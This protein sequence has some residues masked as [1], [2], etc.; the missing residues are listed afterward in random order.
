M[1][2]V[3][4]S[5]AVLS[6]L[7]GFVFVPACGGRA[8]LA[9]GQ[10]DGEAP[11]DDGAAGDSSPSGDDGGTTDSNVTGDSPTSSFDGGEGPDGSVPDSGSQD[12]STTGTDSGTVVDSGQEDSA[13]SA[14]G[15][16]DAG[17]HVCSGQ[18][19]D[20]TAPATCGTSCTPCQA[21]A[22]GVASCSGAACS[23]TCEPGY[24]SCATGC[25]GCGDVQT[26]PNNCGTCGHSCGAEACVDG[27]CGAA[28]IATSQANAY[29]IAADDVNVYWTTTGA[30][31]SVLQAPVGGGGATVLYSSAND[32]PAAIAV[33]SG[34]VYFTDEIQPGSVSRVPIGGGASVPVASNLTYPGALAASGGTLFFTENDYTSQNGGSV[35][36]T[37]VGGGP[38]TTIAGSQLFGQS[39]SLAVAGG[40]VFW[41]TYSDVLMAPAGGGMATTIAS[42]TYAYSVA[43]DA[44]NVYWGSGLNGGVVLQ[45]AIG[46]GSPVTLAS[47]QYYP[48]GIAVDATSVY[49]TTGQ[50]A[51]GTVMKVPIGGG[52]AVTLAANQ[53]DPQAIALNSTRVFWVDFGDGSIK[54]V[55][56]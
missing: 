55:P 14:D 56:K 53:A 20:D 51:A 31:S 4:G 7:C 45:Q 3:R 1:K 22:N 42:Q 30:D 24:T 25:C 16:C 19:V 2:R 15:G 40:S 18:C 12:S 13:P 10:P 17:F 48:N 52:T 49:W 47:G 32:F 44:T 54:S 29:A 43:A 46:G 8:E 26:D 9:P 27:V 34:Q 38:I 36:S 23:Y 11:G 39:T 50:G 28:V 6:A 35:A 21:P 41:T 37:P 33:V 5:L